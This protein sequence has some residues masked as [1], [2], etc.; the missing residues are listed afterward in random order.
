MTQATPVVKDR[1]QHYWDKSAN[2]YDLSY[3]HGLRS[4]LEKTLW[5]DLL[6]RNVQ[7]AYGAKILDVG[8][9]TGFLS[10]LLAEL[11]HSVTGI[12]LSAEM[13]RQA[14]EKANKAGLD[15]TFLPGDAEQPPFPAQSFDAIISRHVVWTLPSPD[16]ALANWR[17]LLK[18]GGSVLIIDGVWTPRNAGS[19]FRHFIADGIKIVQG[20]YKHLFWRRE[21]AHRGELPFFGGAEPE[22]VLQRMEHIGFNNLWHD[23]MEDILHHERHNGPLDYRITHGKNR[24]YLIGGKA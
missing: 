14:A 16:T 18:P 8:S 13:R 11:G 15:V 12:D 10:L 17:Q 21:Y 2:T 22:T 23:Q 20:R 3:G 9:G 1:I 24:R 7:P 6:K 5:L 4:D 19:R